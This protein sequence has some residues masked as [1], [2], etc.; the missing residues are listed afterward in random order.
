MNNTK[1][2]KIVFASMFAALACAATFIKIPVPSMTN[3]YVNLG[4]C[5]VLLAGFFMG[6]LYGGLAAGIGSALTD[7]ISGYIHYAPAT[8]VIKFLMAFTAAIISKNLKKRLPVSIAYIISA[9]VG[10]IIMIAGYFSYELVIYGMGAFGSIFGNLIQGIA[11][12]ISSVAI[13]I[14]LTK[15]KSIMQLFESLNKDSKKNV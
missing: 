5:F 14:I 2:K 7:I 6:P 3:G 9:V 8:L 12:C 13:A 4:D 10:E 11:G 15:N 1:N